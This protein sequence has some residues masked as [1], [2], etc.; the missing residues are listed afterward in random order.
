MEIR[1]VTL[2]DVDSLLNIYSYYVRIPLSRLS[3]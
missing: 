2:D 3:L 1:S